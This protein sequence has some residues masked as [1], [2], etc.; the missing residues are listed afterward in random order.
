M[1][2]RSCWISL[3]LLTLS[4][5]GFHLQ[6]TINLP[7]QFKTIYLHSF[8]P[9]SYLTKETQTMLRFSGIHV[10]DTPKAAP[11]TLD[12][13][14]DNFSTT[15]TSVGGS[16]QLQNYLATYSV[17]F[18]IKNRKGE[19]IFGQKTV[20]DQQNIQILKN[21][22]LSN[23]NKLAQTQKELTHKVINKLFAYLSAKNTVTR[24]SQ[25]HEN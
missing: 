13:L 4:A 10:V 19:S 15:Q 3:I 17:T 20:Q 1:L 16:D 21:E 9:Y 6:G 25:S 23:S 11:M 18:E 5:C 24:L 8:S 12:L 22:V 7:L 14:S 2:K